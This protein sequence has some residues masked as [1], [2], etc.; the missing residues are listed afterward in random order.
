MLAANAAAAELLLAGEIVA[1]ETGR[2]RQLADIMRAISERL[3]NTPAV[4]RKS[5]VHA[6]VVSSYASGKLQALLR[7]GPRPRRLL[8]HRAGAGAA[9][10]AERRLTSPET[11]SPGARQ[12]PESCRA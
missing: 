7:E 3:V 5:Y 6:I 10:G 11:K 9:D 12:T 2:K 4:V 8:A 1:T